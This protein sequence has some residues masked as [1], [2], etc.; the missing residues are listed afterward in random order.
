M[1]CMKNITA[2]NAAKTPAAL[3][4]HLV[5]TAFESA[6]SDLR[7]GVKALEA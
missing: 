1:G 2:L 3:S 7:K 5:W 4:G 6:M